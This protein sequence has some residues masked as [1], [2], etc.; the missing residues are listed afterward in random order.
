MLINAVGIGAGLNE[1]SNSGEVTLVTGG[2]EFRILWKS[3]HG[4]LETESI[5]VKGMVAQ[6]PDQSGVVFSRNAVMP[7]FGSEVR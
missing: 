7:Q 1:F 3:S 5:R 2:D 4:E 6:S